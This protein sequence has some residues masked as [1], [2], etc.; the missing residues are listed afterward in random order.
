MTSSQGIASAATPA[1]IGSISKP[2]EAVIL[3]QL[4]A[5]GRVDL[6]RSV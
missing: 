6:D 1:S 5:E 4:S 3:L 2:V